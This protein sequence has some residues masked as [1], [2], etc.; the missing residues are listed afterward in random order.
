M[1]IQRADILFPVNSTTVDTAAGIDI[2]LLSSAEAG[3]TD[4]TQ[5]VRFLH[6]NDSIER[7]FD[8]ATGLVTV[9][10]D[11]RSFQGEGWA[12]RLTEDHTPVDDNTN[13]NSVLKAGTV[14]IQIRVLQNMNGGTGNIGANPTNYTFRASLWRY[15]TVANTGVSINSGSTLQFWNTATTP[16]DN[17]TYKNIDIPVVVGSDVEFLA[18][19]VLLLQLG[20]FSGTLPNP[21]TGT[22][23][24][25]LTLDV[26]HI[27]TFVDLA[28]EGISLMC[29]L[30][31]N[32]VGE[33]RVPLAGLAITR[34]LPTVVGEGIVAAPGKL[35]VASKTFNLIGEGLVSRTLAVGEFFDLIGEGVSSMTRVVVAAKTFT[36]LG[37]GLVPTATRAVTLARTA[38][39]EGIVSFTKAATVSKTFT[40]L[41][42][43]VVTLTKNTQAVRTFNLIGEGVVTRQMSLGIPRTIVGEG[44]VIFT[45]VVAASKTFTLLGE[46]VVSQGRDLIFVFNLVG[47]GLVTEIHP[48]SAFRTFTLIG[49]GIIVTTGAN[50]STITIPIDEVPDG[51]GGGG[52]DII[53]V[54]KI[55]SPMRMKR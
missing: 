2:R 35:V 53:V 4:S 22:T 30:T 54:N 8:P 47:E 49:E 32:I 45:K 25:D 1:A 6:T 55:F 16:N 3:A 29:A 23:N 31:T 50:T 18:N 24:F 15:D 33:G 17:N 21:I 9:V 38:T 10:A 46:G 5:S 52:G 36:L 37:E 34:T 48:V 27:D 20:V 7:T 14:N 41:G 28:G 19:E 39:G 42:E 11:S 44:L 12:L 26:D 43:G 13:C 40:L 51:G